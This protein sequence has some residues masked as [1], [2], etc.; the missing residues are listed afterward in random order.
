MFQ[1]GLMGATTAELKAETILSSCL[2]GMDGG[3]E[4]GGGGRGGEWTVVFDYRLLC[5]FALLSCML[6][7]DKTFENYLSSQL[8]PQVFL[9]PS[10]HLPFGSFYNPRCCAAFSPVQAALLE[11][12]AANATSPRV[13]AACLLFLSPPER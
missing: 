7:F 1:A 10:S 5:Q 2:W 3:R 11:A 13:L 6:Y 9:I 8:L 4:W 12:S